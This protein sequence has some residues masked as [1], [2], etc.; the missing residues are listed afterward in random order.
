MSVRYTAVQGNKVQVMFSILSFCFA[1]SNRQIMTLFIS[2]FQ[3]IESNGWT[4]REAATIRFFKFL[5]V[6]VTFSFAIV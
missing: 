1:K 3:F 6:Q 5:N 4:D 2:G